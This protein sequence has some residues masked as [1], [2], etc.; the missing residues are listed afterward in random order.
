MRVRPRSRPRSETSSARQRTQRS[1]SLLRL[2]E[3]LIDAE[4]RN[5]KAEWVHPNELVRHVSS[6]DEVELRHVRLVPT[7]RPCSGRVQQ[8][9]KGDGCLVGRVPDLGQADVLNGD[10]YLVFRRIREESLQRVRLVVLGDRRVRECRL[11]KEQRVRIFAL[12]GRSDAAEVLHDELRQEVPELGWLGLVSGGVVLHGLSAADVVD[13]NDEW[14]HVGVRGDGSEIERHEPES[15]QG[16][17]NDGDLQIRVHDQR[18]A[19]QLYE[20]A[21][22]AFKRLW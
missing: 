7:F 17:E 22:G 9:L 5:L 12:Y 11:E 6:D 18:R 21:L 1:Q 15:N 4:I 8:L 3:C 20:L 2:L 10:V 14:L 16:E 13:A 19:V